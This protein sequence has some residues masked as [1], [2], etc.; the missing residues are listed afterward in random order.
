MWTRASLWLRGVAPALG[1]QLGSWRLSVV[2]TVTVA[3]FYAHLAIFSRNSPSEM[4]RNIAA[5]VVFWAIYGA[6]LVNTAACLWLR[7]PT[8]KRE[9]AAHPHLVATPPSWEVP[10]V[11]NDAVA[12]EA[13]RRRGF[14]VEGQGPGQL[15]G[16]RHRF[17]SLGTWFF[18]GSFF[19]VAAGFLT[20]LAFREEYRL[21]IAVGEEF[22][23]AP[24]Q[25]VSRQGSGLVTLGL[26]DLRFTHERITPRFHE[27][28]LLFTHLDSVVRLEGQAPVEAEINKPV[29]L[30]PATSLRLTGFGYAPRYELRV[31][32]GPVVG[33]SFLK[34]RVFPPG[35]EDVFRPEGYP[36]R[37]S[38]QV[39]P[40]LVEEGGVP[41]TRSLNLVRPGFLVRVMR[42]RVDLGQRLLRGGDDPFLFEGL[43]LRFPEVQYWGEF[44]VLRDPG[45]PI[46]LAGFLMALVGLGLK[47]RG[48][49]QEVEWSAARGTLRG[50]GG[51]PP[52][53][54]S[55]GGA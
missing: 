16:V 45:A 22:T 2:L 28:Q 3:F 54:L 7:F 18:H 21:L 8:L 33:S 19:V 46:L 26:P 15:L 50:W 1:R 36:H 4:V 27:G 55:Q 10:L 34:L 6:L 5:L 17:A 12:T 14:S 43:E 31:S 25:I 13:L 37:V 49:R 40:D 35:V 29:W 51:E 48:R 38:L 24:E 32:G 23:G 47:L 11:V 30:S 44:V 41:S 42:A 20:T 9:L 53:D 39:L 52:R